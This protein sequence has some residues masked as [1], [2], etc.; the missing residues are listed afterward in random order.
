MDK[1]LV[2]LSFLFLFFGCTG[3]TPPGQT[4]NESAAIDSTEVIDM[5]NSRISLDWPGTYQGVLPCADCQGIKTKIILHEDLTYQMFTQYLGRDEPVFSRRGSFAWDKEGG[6][7]Y[8]TDV[9]PMHETNHYRVGENRLFKL[10]S[11]GQR[12][13]GELE[14]LYILEK[15]NE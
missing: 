13:R 10:D 15:L 12:I 14:A 7:I 4:A 2:H 11:H 6:T 1:I 3:P 5:H 9:D 8:L